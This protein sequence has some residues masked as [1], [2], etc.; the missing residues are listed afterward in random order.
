IGFATGCAQ[1]RDTLGWEQ[2]PKLGVPNSEKVSSGNRPAPT[3][4]ADLYA[5]AIRGV[6]PKSADESAQSV[7][8]S[9]PTTA[10]DGSQETASRS[11][12][13]PDVA[14]PNDG[15]GRRTHTPESVVL[16]TPVAL[17]TV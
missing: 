7:A 16:Q 15:S 10:P 11:T 12:A 1:W 5:D 14:S 17:P 3:P 13:H 8:S 6:R 9:R 4:G 2:R